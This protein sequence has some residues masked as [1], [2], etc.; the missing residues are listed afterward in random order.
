MA[1]AANEIH[2]RVVA[3][4]QAWQAN[5]HLHKFMQPELR[6][7]IENLTLR[8]KPLLAAA[9]DEQGLKD[10]TAEVHG[11]FDRTRTLLARVQD[12]VRFFFATRP[13]VLAALAPLKL[14]AEPEEDVIRLANLRQGLAGF[15][16]PHMHWPEDLKVED[17]DLAV[18]AHMDA[19]RKLDEMDTSVRGAAQKLRALRVES[20]ALWE[21]DGLDAWIVANV[22]KHDEQLAWGRERTKRARPRNGDGAVAPAPLVAEPLS[23][24]AQL[25]TG[26]SVAPVP[27]MGA[28][29]GPAVETGV[30]LRSTADDNG[31]SVAL[32]K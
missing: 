16:P 23:G 20:T 27:S 21:E 26:V 29:T 18:A 11:V 2:R 12:G 22:H 17:L 1:I 31:S 6:H 32:P 19:R 14:G 15:E 8:L 7:K 5:P 10:T 24:P 3:A 28:T 13:D 4:W 25:K 30:P 9:D